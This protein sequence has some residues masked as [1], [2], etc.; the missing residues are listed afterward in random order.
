MRSVELFTGADGL[1]IAMS[2][3]GFRHAAVLER[4]HDPCET[5][6]VSRRPPRQHGA[7]SDAGDGLASDCPRSPAGDHHAGGRRCGS[8]GRFRRPPS[9][10]NQAESIVDFGL[11]ARRDVNSAAAS[12]TSAKN[13]S[14]VIGAS[15]WSPSRPCAAC[16]FCTNR[17]YSLT[18]SAVAE[19]DHVLGIA[20]LPTPVDAVEALEIVGRLGR[21]TEIAE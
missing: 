21:A 15:T 16:S 18:S 19:H 7:P 9:G 11:Y 10:H 17:S 2:N 3:A 5:F 1:A 20:L 4:N 13:S 8:S 14:R 6:R 12:R